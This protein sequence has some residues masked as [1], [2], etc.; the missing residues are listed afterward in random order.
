[1]RSIDK[2]NSHQYSLPV[3]IENPKK[4]GKDYCKRMAEGIFSI[5]MRSVSGIPLG[6]Q[7]RFPYL[8]SYGDGSQSI[9][10]YLDYFFKDKADGDDAV[11]PVSDIDGATSGWTSKNKERIRKGWMNIMLDVISPAPK[12]L[13]TLVSKFGKSEYD[14][15][16]D[17]VDSFSS[18]Q[19]EL[20]KANLWAERFM[21]DF[22]KRYYARMGVEYEPSEF[23]PESLDEL[24]VWEKEGGIKLPYAMIMED[25]AANTMDESGWKEIKKKMMADAVNLR[26]F[27]CKDDYNEETGLVESKYVDPYEAIVQYSQYNDYRDAEYAGHVEKYSISKLKILMADYDLN[28]KEWAEIANSYSGINDNPGAAD[29]EYYNKSNNDG[30]YGYDFYKVDV[31]CCEWITTDADQALI[32]KNRYGKKKV[33]PQ[34]LGTENPQSDKNQTRIKKVRMKYMAKWIIG[35]DYVFDFGKAWDIVRPKTLKEPTLSYHFYRLPVKSITEQLIPIYDNFFILWLKYQNALAMAV[36]DGYAIDYDAISNVDMGDSKMSQEDVIKRFLQTGILIFRRTKPG[37]NPYDKSQVPVSQ[38]PGGLSKVFS[39]FRVGF[40]IN[41]QLIEQLTGFTPVSIGGQPER[42]VSVTAS[43]RSLEATNEYLGTIISGYLRIKELMVENVTAWIRLKIKQGKG[44]DFAYRKKYGDESVNLIKQ[45]DKY[46]VV[47]SFE[48]T[49]RPTDPERKEIFEAAKV[50]L[51]SGRD[52]KPGITYGDYFAIMNVLSKRGS[53]K[54]AWM[55][56]NSAEQRAK[57]QAEEL[58][59]KNMRIQAEENRKSEEQKAQQA[60]AQQR[61]KADL[62]LRNKR[63]ELQI[64]DQNAQ[65][66][67]VRA[68]ERLSREGEL[69]KELKRIE[70]QRNDNNKN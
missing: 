55:I 60:A 70:S 45:I 61:G 51:N 34:E 4:K 56:L 36:N 69:D 18:L 31:F 42:D 23:I 3:D 44:A 30:E 33:I 21:M 48:F 54:R 38:L 59:E 29:F 57:R 66:E 12:V 67:H 11:S 26:Y 49:P 25:M 24:E 7:S 50:S 8:R 37:G 14:V 20:A 62:E 32:R 13:S 19:T 28:E 5:H 58:A 43:E 68:M 10:K 53:L 47:Y 35:T 15:V 64:E 17:A 39:D 65:K 9:D 46:G 40:L 6:E 41:S 22:N 2:Y 52:G 1:M 63:E 16:C 27:V